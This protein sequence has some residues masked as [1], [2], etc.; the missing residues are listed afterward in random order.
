MEIRFLT[1]AD[2]QRWWNLR[3][4]ALRLDPHAFSA[5]ADE[6]ESLSLEEV[7][8]RIGSVTEDSF[9]VG[10]FDHCNLVGM[11]GFYRE[12]GIKSRHKGRIWGVYVTAPM[13]NAGVGRKMLQ[14]L[15]LR[16]RHI[17]GL[18]QILLSVA[19]T[20][21]AAAHLYRSLGFVSYGREP[22]ALRIADQWIDEDYMVLMLDRPG[23]IDEIGSRHAS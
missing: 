23:S 20:Q 3:R 4:E 6:H 1:A 13:R 18:K 5:S 19:A 11:A 10:A 2:A 16:A 21:T 22:R 12:K 8:R 9:L 14:M 17:E 7:R 15:L